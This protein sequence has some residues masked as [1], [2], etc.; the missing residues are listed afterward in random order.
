MFNNTI[1]GYQND[2]QDAMFIVQTPGAV[3]DSCTF[4]STMMSEGVVIALLTSTGQ[5]AL[6]HSCVFLGNF[7]TVFH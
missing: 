1:S 2:A 4:V 5:P 3:F 7:G 6:F